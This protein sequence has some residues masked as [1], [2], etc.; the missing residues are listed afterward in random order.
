MILI[1]G[2]LLASFVVL[3]NH[4][5][6][7]LRR[8]TEDTDIGS[9][10]THVTRRGTIKSVKNSIIKNYR[11]SEVVGSFSIILNTIGIFKET[12]IKKS[13]GGVTGGLSG[14]LC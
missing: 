11:N 4:L 2:I 14:G 8:V 10:V 1:K 3:M 12:V 6:E 9:L 13:D 5:L 7:T